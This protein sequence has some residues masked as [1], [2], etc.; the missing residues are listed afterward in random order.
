MEGPGPLHISDTDRIGE[1]APLVH[2]VIVT[3]EINFLF[4]FLQI[5]VVSFYPLLKPRSS[6]LQQ[7]IR[8]VKF[9]GLF[10][11]ALFITT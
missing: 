7:K 11:A 6:T 2:L 10:S 4:S 1:I 9:C 3:N 8:P 5:L